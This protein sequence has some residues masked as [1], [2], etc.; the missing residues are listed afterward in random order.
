MVIG[1]TFNQRPTGCGPQTCGEDQFAEFDTPETVDLLSKALAT[2]GHKPIQVGDGLRLIDNLRKGAQFDLIFNLAEGRSFQSREAQVPAILDL[3]EVPYTFGDPLCMCVCLNKAVTK[4]L[5][6]GHGIPTSPAFLASCGG[7]IP[8][9]YTLPWE[10]FVKPN[11]EGTSK[12]IDEGAIVDSVAKL[13]ARINFIRDTYDQMSLI[14]RRV[15]GKEYTIAI[16]G[17]GF[18]ARALGASR[19]CLPK[20]RRVYGVLEKER[21]ETLVK[22]QFEKL[23]TRYL[24]FAVSVYRATGC[25]D[26]GRVDMII[27]KHGVPF[28]L[29]VNPLP[30]LHPTHSDL[31]I[32]ASQVG[33]SYCDLIGSI[34]SSACHRKSGSKIDSESH[35][36]SSQAPR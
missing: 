29:E 26:A 36:L 21:C 10:A 1:I 2:L 7:D 23:H 25:R 28:I 33:L 22:Y 8:P 18:D 32:V 14:E 12:G 4:L 20:G 5:L 13:R 3:F 16:I 19:I 30:G 17:S 9:N 24:D 31:P 34:V 27:D 35:W 11:H 15:S 6:Q